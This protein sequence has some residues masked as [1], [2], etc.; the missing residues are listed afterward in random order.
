MTLGGLLLSAL[1]MGHWGRGRGGMRGRMGSSSLVVDAEGGGFLRVA[2]DGLFLSGHDVL[3]ISFVLLF[4]CNGGYVNGSR[5][6]S[7][8]IFL[9]FLVFFLTFFL[10]RRS[11]SKRSRFCG[12]LLL[13]D[14]LLAVEQVENISLVSPLW[15][16]SG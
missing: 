12:D 4:L 16:G 8:L 13:G 11:R 14:A 6:C 1:G 5:G 3:E 7:R 2:V 10:S 15:S 9:I